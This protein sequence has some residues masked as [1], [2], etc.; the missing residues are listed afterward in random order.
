MHIGAPENAAPP[1]RS[2]E[3]SAPPHIP[4][5]NTAVYPLSLAAGCEAD[6]KINEG[7]EGVPQGRTS[8]RGVGKHHG[9]TR[10]SLASQ[11]RR[12]SPSRQ[13]RQRKQKIPS[14][15]LNRKIDAVLCLLGDS[16]AK[17]MRLQCLFVGYTAGDATSGTEAINW[18]AISTLAAHTKSIENLTSSPRNRFAAN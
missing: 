17:S 9:I 6:G 13:S 3:P 10:Q 8:H 16:F 1:A 12:R 15:K 7:Y 14:Q 2:T 5:A 18:A 4:P 11:T